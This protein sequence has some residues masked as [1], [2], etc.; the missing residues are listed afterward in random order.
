[1]WCRD[2]KVDRTTGRRCYI[3]TEQIWTK[4]RRDG[5]CVVRVSSGGDGWKGNK[6]EG[7]RW[8]AAV[9]FFCKP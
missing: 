7:E 1:W 9:S 3:L 4:R 6:D 5:D 2:A 8:A